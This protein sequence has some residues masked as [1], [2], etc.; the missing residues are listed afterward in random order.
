MPKEY[1]PRKL[2]MRGRQK[3][4]ILF[5]LPVQDKPQKFRAKKMREVKKKENQR[6]RRNN[7]IKKTESSL[8]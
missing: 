6:L 7:K 2:T 5:I 3:I 4:L 8:R 1:Y